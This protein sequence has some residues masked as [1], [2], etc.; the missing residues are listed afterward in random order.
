MKKYYLLLPLILFFFQSKAQ[1]L[2]TNQTGF[3]TIA[4]FSNKDVLGIQFNLIKL[5]D[6]TFLEVKLDSELDNEMDS[7]FSVCNPG[8]SVTF[9]FDTNKNNNFQFSL[10]IE[11]VME[12]EVNSEIKRLYLLDKQDIH[13]L[14]L[15]P[16]KSIRINIDNSKEYN[17]KNIKESNFFINNLK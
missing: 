7:H 2:Q 14:L 15:N 5:N 16:I 6:Y 10:R 11:P 3:K 12:N 1:E 9:D 13:E 17:F 8:I 4:Y